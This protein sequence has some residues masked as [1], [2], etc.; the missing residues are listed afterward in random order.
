MTGC[1]AGSRESRGLELEGFQGDAMN[2]ETTKS[3][4]R[5]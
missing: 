5:V 3:T 2:L 1:F 4:K